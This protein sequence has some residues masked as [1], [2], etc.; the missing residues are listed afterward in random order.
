MKLNKI[1]FIEKFVLITFPI[2]LAVGCTTTTDQQPKAASV[3]ETTLSYPYDVKQAD[4]SE[5]S[6]INTPSVNVP[7]QGDLMNTQTNAA[8]Y[9]TS[10][11]RETTNTVYK[12]NTLEVKVRL[13]GTPEKAKPTKAIFQFHAN[14]YDIGGADL[15][16]LIQ[17]AR[18]LKKH[19]NLVLHVDGF[20]DNRGSAYSNYQLSKKRAQQIAELLK[21]YGAPG[22]QIKVN[23]YGESFPINNEKNWDENRR[24]E[25]EYVNTSL[26]SGIIASNK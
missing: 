2:A 9:K 18:Y 5:S 4:V 1:S 26:S 6:T 10:A 11:S 20:S 8:Y 22:S 7:A 17:H 14:K 16:V 3:D 15:E 25:L 24:V 23:G 12:D 19:P 13:L 21:S